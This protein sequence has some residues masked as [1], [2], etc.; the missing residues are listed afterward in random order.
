MTTT[1]DSRSAVH[2]KITNK[3]PE[4]KT[5][6]SRDWSTALLDW[7]MIKNTNGLNNCEEQCASL[8][9]PRS[10]FFFW[11]APP[12]LVPFLIRHFPS[13]SNP[14]NPN[15]HNP[16]GAKAIQHTPSFYDTLS[17]H[18]CLPQLYCALSNAV[19]PLAPRLERTA[20]DRTEVRRPTNRCGR[21]LVT[22]DATARR[23]VDGISRA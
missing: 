13:L 8:V 14:P 12:P 19:L 9:F 3:K 6:Q 22:P 17:F 21:P 23:Q 20:A 4:Q 18:S 10:L 5:D 15:A 11:F 7:T 1:G 16:S 2:S